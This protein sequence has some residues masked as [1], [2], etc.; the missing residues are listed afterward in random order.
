MDTYI[1][2][3][4]KQL[5]ASSF[6]K[7]W[8]WFFEQ[9]FTKEQVAEI[10]SLCERVEEVDAMTESGEEPDFLVRN[11]K[12]SW[13][14]TEELYALV[15]PV[16]HQVNAQAGWNYSITAIEPVQYTI[17]YGTENNHY[18]WHTD[19]IV[20]DI[21]HE[22][23]MKDTVRKISCSILLSDPSEYEGG[24]FEFLTLNNR[25]YL[26]E[27]K[28]IFDGEPIG[29]PNFYN[30]GAALFFP[31]YSFHRVKPVTKGVRQ[32]LVCWFRG[33]KWV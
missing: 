32:S 26:K 33:P 25:E 9:A 15:R 14:D 17:Y 16:M 28:D 22:G 6:E 13:H 8:F 19:T 30:E 21:Q 4:G 2:F 5:A 12:I 1:S 29:I 18:S 3:E 11:N 27:K 24:E 31:S 7:N 23:V 10:R 20:N